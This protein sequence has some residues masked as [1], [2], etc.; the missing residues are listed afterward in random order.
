M[1]YTFYKVPKE[2]VKSSKSEGKINFILSEM[3]R[4]TSRVILGYS[5][6]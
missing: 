5:S 1:K 4:R 2:C 3:K 6:Q